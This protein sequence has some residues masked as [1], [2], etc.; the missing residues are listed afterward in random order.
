MKIVTVIG[1]R[2]QFIK[3]WPVSRALEAAGIAEHVIHTGQ[4]YDHDMSGIF[5]EQLGMREPE[6]NLAVGSRTQ[7]AQTAR[8][9][10]GIEAVLLREKPDGVLLYGDTN[11]TVAGA[12]AAVKL[13]IPIAHVEAGLRSF[14]RRMPEEHNRIITDHCS[15]LLFCPTE[16]AIANL[17]NEGLTKGVHLCGDVMKDAVLLAKP[18][19]DAC[20][21][22]LA[23]LGLS[24]NA[25]TLATLHRA[26]NVDHEDR[27]KS[28]L[29]GLE[30]LGL[31]VI[32][33]VHPRTRGKIE[34]LAG[35]GAGFTNLRMIAPVGYLD[36]IALMS[37][38]RA[39]LTDSG[40]LQKEAVWLGRPCITLRDETEWVETVASGKNRLAGADADLIRESFLAFEQS[41][42]AGNTLDAAEDPGS[43]RIAAL[44]DEHL[45]PSA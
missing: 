39:V 23:D 4:H 28:I 6:T 31:P 20:S 15:D 19:A 45:S 36:M 7:G 10:E 14:N 27:L 29:Q 9:L 1:A 43:G 3:A 34:A 18:R 12:L 26:E 42:P 37:H 33:P 35:R 32:F 16:T 44:L 41:A 38:S 17:R 5:F 24:P 13:H 2:P 8:M 30:S 21:T 11:S 22:I 25:Y 40:G